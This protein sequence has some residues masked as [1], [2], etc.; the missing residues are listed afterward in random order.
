MSQHTFAV[1]A[2]KESPHLQECINSLKKQT[3]QSNIIICTS[4]PS[5]F[6]ENIASKNNLTL[7]INSEKNG[8]ASD[9]NF[10]L[11]Q[12]TTKYATLAHQDDVYFPEYCEKI[13]KSAELRKDALLIFANYDELIQ[14]NGQTV[15]RKNSLNFFI[16]KML[17][18][19][20]FKG[21]QAR[22]KNKKHLLA[23]G[24]PIGCPT[25]TFAKSNLEN[26]EFDKNFSINLDWKAW[27]DLAEK[28]GAFNW[29]N[30]TL[31]SHRIYAESETSQG[32]CENR[33]QKEDLLIFKKN[34]PPPVAT[35]ISKLYSL[36]YKNNHK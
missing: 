29:I 16:K 1:L 4:T 22:T 32:L 7:F 11:K 19:L 8:I 36:S 15:V 34:F 27:L 31:V 24:N 28:K 26:F 10:A 35:L 14:Q 23:F 30:E 9:W 3:V 21:K 17:L 2:Y 18:K 25:V 13:L 5:T 12:T 33:R 20:F 6:L